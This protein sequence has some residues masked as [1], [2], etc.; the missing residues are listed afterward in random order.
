MENVQYNPYYDEPSSS[1]NRFDEIN[2]ITRI[3]SELLLIKIIP[4]VTGSAN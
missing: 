3:Y 2:D 4:D 1:P